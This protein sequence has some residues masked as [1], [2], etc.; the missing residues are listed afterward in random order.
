VLSPSAATEVATQVDLE[1][2]PPVVN[3]AIGALLCVGEE[4]VVAQVVD[5]PIQPVNLYRNTQALFQIASLWNR[6]SSMH[7][8]FS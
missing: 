6:L 4:H 3:G 8:F 5:S 1:W 7:R 2:T